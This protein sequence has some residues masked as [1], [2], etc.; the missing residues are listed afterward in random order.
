MG[1]AK[2]TAEKRLSAVKQ[3]EAD[4]ALNLEQQKAK[5]TA[6]QAE[7]SDDMTVA[8]EAHTASVE[9]KQKL[10][11]EVDASNAQT[12]DADMAKTTAKLA[13][14][15]ASTTTHAAQTKTEEAAMV[16]AKKQQEADTARQLYESSS[17]T[18][19]ETEASLKLKGT[20]VTDVQLMFQHAQDEEAQKLSAHEYHEAATKVG[21]LSETAS[22]A[23]QNVA[24]AQEN[25]KTIGMEQVSTVAPSS[26]SGTPALSNLVQTLLDVGEVNPN[27]N[28]MQ[29]LGI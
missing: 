3:A 21:A 20:K 8:Q 29:E 18:S 22:K 13:S 15:I 26:T 16:S 24:A 28:E 10:K 2:H 1:A 12:S 7:A 11:I 5:A 19:A 6:S 4:A 9:V 23:S 14:S 17:S 27:S 25:L